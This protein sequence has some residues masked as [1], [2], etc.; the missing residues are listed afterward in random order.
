MSNLSDKDRLNLQ[1]MVKSYGADDNTKKIRE[2][3]H[4]KQLKETVLVFMNLK[5]KYSRML[6]NDKKS[7]EKIAMKHCNFLWVNYTNIFNRLLKDELDLK[8]LLKFIEKLKQIEDGDIDQHEAS[9]EIGKILKSMYVDSALKREKKFEEEE[10]R[11]GNKK[12]KKEKKPVKNI[13][14]ARFKSQGL[15]STE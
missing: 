13:S 11:K 3:K 4:S 9:V 12:K 14:W 5:K 15:A 10:I 8:I 6:L 2:L 7:F 1:Q